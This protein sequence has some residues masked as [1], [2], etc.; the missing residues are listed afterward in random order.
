MQHAYKCYQELTRR[1]GCRTLETDMGLFHTVLSVFP[2]LQ[3]LTLEHVYAWRRQ[4]LDF[5][6]LHNLIQNIWM[7]PSF[8]GFINDALMRLLPALESYPRIKR[9]NLSGLL[10]PR[11][12]PTGRYTTIQH[13]RLDSILAGEGLHES[14]IRCLESFPELT[15]LTISTSPRGPINLQRLPLHHLQWS[16][17]RNFTLARTWTSEDELLSFVERHHLQHLSIKSV[18]LSDGTWES[19]FNRIRDIR[20]RPTIHIR[21]LY[22]STAVPVA[23]PNLESQRLLCH[24]LA[25]KD[26]Q[27]PFTDRDGDVT[28]FHLSP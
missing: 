20:S 26:F 10:D 27:W 3:E 22:T 4:R 28:V 21:G 18:L 16:S 8:D 24:F 5:V 11:V 19:F 23:L 15:S 12:M 17:L 6:H 14:I 1:E 2:S 7:V 13:L 25:H 9:L